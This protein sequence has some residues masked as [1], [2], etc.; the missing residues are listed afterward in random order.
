MMDALTAS[1]IKD[2]LYLEENPEET[3]EKD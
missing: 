2:T 3:S 1:N